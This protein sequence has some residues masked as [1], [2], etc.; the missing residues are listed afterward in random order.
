MI[1]KRSEQGAFL[2]QISHTQNATWQGTINWLDENKQ[3]PFRSTLELIKLIDNAMGT[4][5]VQ[6][7]WG[8]AEQSN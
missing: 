8:D 4:P 7:E 1:K 6:T 2:I 5:L 3:Q